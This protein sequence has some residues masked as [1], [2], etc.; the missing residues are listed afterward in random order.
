MLVEDSYEDFVGTSIKK[1]QKQNNRE[2]TAFI[3]DL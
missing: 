1:K 2:V 3:I